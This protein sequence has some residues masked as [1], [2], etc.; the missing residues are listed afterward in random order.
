MV[1]LTSCAISVAPLPPYTML[2]NTPARPAPVGWL[3]GNFYL[4]VGARLAAFGTMRTLAQAQT[5]ELR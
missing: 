4:A 1:R 3:A 2:S 5:N